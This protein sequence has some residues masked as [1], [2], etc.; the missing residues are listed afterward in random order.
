MTESD[1]SLNLSA[2]VSGTGIGE[3]KD[4]SEHDNLG[5]GEFGE[6]MAKSILSLSGEPLVMMLEGSWGSGKTVF[7]KQWAALMRNRGCSVIR[8]DAFAVDYIQD[9]FVA[10]AGEVGLLRERFGLPEAIFQKFIV[11]A[12]TAVGH[13]IVR[14]ATGDVVDFE[15]IAGQRDRTA[16]SFE[17]RIKSYGK[18]KEAVLAMR[19]ALT[20]ISET[21]SAKALDE[22]LEKVQDD[23]TKKRELEDGGTG[24]L[25]FIVDELDRCR[26]DFALGILEVIKHFFSVDGVHFILVANREQ[27]AASVRHV[28]G[29]GK[30]QSQVY[31]EKFFL[32]SLRMPSAS[33]ASLFSGANYK[34]VDYLAGKCGAGAECWPISALCFLASS[35]TGMSLRDIG[36]IMLLLRL[37]GALDNETD[38][39]LCTFPA[40]MKVL[41]P[42]RY[43]QLLSGHLPV[44]E[45]HTF[46]EE[47]V[48]AVK[49]TNSQQYVDLVRGMQDAF[50]GLG[51]LLGARQDAPMFGFL[52]LEREVRIGHALMDHQAI[53]DLIDGW[54][55][56]ANLFPIAKSVLGKMV[57]ERLETINLS[58]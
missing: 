8:M 34:Y 47:H 50:I 58:G 28:Y 11:A 7:I 29:C 56:D 15:K 19:D 2:L 40:F 44:T 4:F 39:Y 21:A 23:E 30:S 53:I 54:L 37:S 27:L 51:L 31:L 10:I 14:N 12:A 26:P 46:L 18:E 6:R 42:D 38:A 17:N 13:A 48:Q 3:D 35:S 33:S 36:K 43:G 55:T 16:G 5:F 52:N 45:L 32:F 24:P 22:A 9:P 20:E 49:K 41:S 57:S 1:A 25:I